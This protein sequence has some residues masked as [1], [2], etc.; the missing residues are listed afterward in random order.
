M[1]KKLIT[2]ISLVVTFFAFANVA[3]A[4]GPYAYE[5]EVPEELK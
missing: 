2:L 4:T 1:K 3:A 5:P